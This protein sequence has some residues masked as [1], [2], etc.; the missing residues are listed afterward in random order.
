M[1][2]RAALLMS[3]FGLLAFSLTIYLCAPGY[4]A[5]DSGGQLEQ[6]R[7]FE[8]VDDHPVLMAL[9]WR[10]IDRVLPGPLGMLVFMNAMW[11]G[12]LA[13]LFWA[14]PI[15]LPA[16]AV[17][18]LAVGFFPPVFSALPIVLKDGVM[19]GALLLGL[20][21]IVVPGRGYRA[22]LAAGCALFILAIGLR[23]NALAAVWPFLMLPLLRLPVWS[24]RPRWLRLLAAAGVSI[25]LTCGIALGLKRSL[26]PI[27][28]ETNFWQK[29][30]IFDLAG[31]S[32]R[33]GQVLVDPEAHVLTPGMGVAEMRPLFSI[34]YGPRLY[35]CTAF[36]GHPCVT[37]FRVTQDPQE[38]HRLSQSW[39]SAVLHHPGAYLA[40]RGAF[41]RELLRMSPGRQIYYLGPGP[42]HP[43]AANY[44][45]P[46]RSLALLAFIDRQAHSFHF[47]PWLYLLL[48]S[49]VLPFA[50]VRYL[51]GG[52]VL[53]LLFALSGLVYLLSVVV[54]A[55]TPDFR[56]TAWMIVCA[57]LGIVSLLADWYARRSTVGTRAEAL[58]HYARAT[59]AT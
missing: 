43:L 38:L 3:L 18:M 53:P 58:R 14:L 20:A 33:T 27:A 40:H 45:L 52:S 55:I 13:G 35:Y 59:S 49:L 31:M 57:V 17:G 39:F 24:S 22:R 36:G 21:C 50:L 23:H 46:E 7:S 30:S 41:A 26:A 15:P 25:L 42:R 34:D 51:R 44:P 4:M 2:R 6:A 10:Y 37:V 16:R 19:H 1:N 48:N 54:G 9:I 5:A 56:Y 47:A 11:W 32:L 29:V 8:F 12:G 28:R